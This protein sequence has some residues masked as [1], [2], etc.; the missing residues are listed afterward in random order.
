MQ[1]QAEAPKLLHQSPLSHVPSQSHT[2]FSLP[3]NLEGETVKQ[4]V[5]LGV[6]GG[7]IGIGVLLAVVAVVLQ[8]F[9]FAYFVILIYGMIMAV[10][11]GL[12]TVS[13]FAIMEQYD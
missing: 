2:T 4:L 12:L 9:N 7:I 11:I 1:S 10:V 6:Q 3:E 5:R 13:R 8:N